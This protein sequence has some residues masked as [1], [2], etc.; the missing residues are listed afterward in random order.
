M[1]CP[2]CSNDLAATPCNHG[3]IPTCTA[4]RGCAITVE[5]LRRFA[6]KQRVNAMWQRAHEHLPRGVLECPSCEAP[7]RRLTLTEGEAGLALDACVPCHLIWFDADELVAF[8]P[9]RQA[10]PD[11]EEERRLAAEGMGISDSDR[12]RLT[13]SHPVWQVWRI[14]GILGG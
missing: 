2:R 8:S 11:A 3:R 4:C 12:A 10:P 7:M 1:R 13:P 6:P 5:M 14:V 9:D